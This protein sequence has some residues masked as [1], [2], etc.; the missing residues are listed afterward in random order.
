[1]RRRRFLAAAGSAAV[2]S[3]AGCMGLSAGADDWDV[4]MT[5]EA[6]RPYEFTTTVGE[7]VVW[8]N[9]SSRDHS[10]T[11]YEDTLP[12]GAEFFATGGFDSEA[13]AR[14]AWKDG[15][16]AISNGQQFG[17]TFE[18]PGEYSYF[19]IPHEKGGMVGTIIVE[20]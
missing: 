13:A 9:T 8:E 14:E 11:A 17:H 10:V 19:C 20:E 12:D 7:E 6:F 2:L 3:A 15:R 16:G 4:G 5:S 1:M 18:V